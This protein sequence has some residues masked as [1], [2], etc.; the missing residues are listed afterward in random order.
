MTVVE[1]V[2]RER[3]RLARRIAVT[4]GAAAVAVVGLLLAGGVTLLGDA[5]W[6]ALPRPMPLLVWGAA[7]AMAAGTVWW[8]RRWLAREA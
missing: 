6:M 2:E 8:T 4:G 5:R 3:S 7:L 1:L